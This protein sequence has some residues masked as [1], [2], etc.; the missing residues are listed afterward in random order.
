MHTCDC[1]QVVGH[2]LGARLLLTTLPLL[3]TERWPA[4]L[5]LCA[6]AATELQARPALERLACTNG[7]CQAYIYYSPRD[8]V[9]TTGFRLVAPHG[10][11]AIGAAPLEHAHRHVHNIDATP[12]FAETVFVHAAFSAAFDRMAQDAVRR[13]APPPAR[14]GRSVAAQSHWLRAAVL[15]SLRWSG[16]T[17]GQQPSSKVPESRDTMARLARRLAQKAAQGSRRGGGWLGIRP[18]Q[19]KG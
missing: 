9:L 17:F 8:E 15:D 16:T 7:A 11:K 6:A 3:S 1:R 19:G 14:A 18:K 5:H 13:R 2:S 12:Y 10:A 4:E